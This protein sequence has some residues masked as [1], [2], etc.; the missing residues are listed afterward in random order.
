MKLKVMQVSPN[1]LAV[2]MTVCVC[3]LGGS[4][5]S[6]EEDDD[7]EWYRQEVGEEPDPGQLSHEG[8]HFCMTIRGWYRTI[9]ICWFQVSLTRE[10]GMATQM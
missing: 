1:L 10:R 4:E 8:G 6:S 5:E 3:V 7:T 2:Y 9:Q